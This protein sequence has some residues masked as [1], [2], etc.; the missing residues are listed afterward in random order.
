MTCTDIKV[1]AARLASEARIRASV[2][3]RKLGG[4]VNSA[5]KN[6]LRAV[7]GASLPEE[8]ECDAASRD[9]CLPIEI[10]RYAPLKP[11]R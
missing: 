3:P 8:R 9:S 6:L 5:R 1:I 10:R 11:I 7:H 4:K 2:Y